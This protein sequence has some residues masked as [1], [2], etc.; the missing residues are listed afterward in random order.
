MCYEG[1]HL[2]EGDVLA[3]CLALVTWNWT[4]LLETNGDILAGQ[5]L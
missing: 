1:S 5:D 4:T 2:S 3:L